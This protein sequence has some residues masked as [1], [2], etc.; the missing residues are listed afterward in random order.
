MVV[1]AVCSVVVVADGVVARVGSDSS[2]AHGTDVAVV[3]V[4]DGVFVDVVVVVVVADATGSHTSADWASLFVDSVGC[5]IAAVTG[6]VTRNSAVADTASA[7]VMFR[8]RMKCGADIKVILPLAYLAA[9]AAL[10]AAPGL[11]KPNCQAR[12][13][14]RTDPVKML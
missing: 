8:L 9:G 12:H 7:R 14:T 11:S 3:V 10:T 13:R 5:A 6:V 1:G 2:G 4:L